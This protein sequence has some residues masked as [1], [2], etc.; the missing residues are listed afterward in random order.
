MLSDAAWCC[1]VMLHGAA[2]CCV[3]LRGAAWC[4]VVWC[5][6][7]LV[8]VGQQSVGWCI[9]YWCLYYILSIYKHTLTA[10]TTQQT[11]PQHTART[12]CLFTHDE[13]QTSYRKCP[14]PVIWSSQFLQRISLPRCCDLF[15]TNNLQQVSPYYL[16]A[17]LFAASASPPCPASLAW[18]A[19]G[20]FPTKN[21]KEQQEARPCDPHNN[22]VRVLLSVAQI[23]AYSPGEDRIYVNHKD[24]LFAIFDGHGGGI[25]I[26]RSIIIVI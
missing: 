19:G 15:N 12:R 4:C 24:N 9:Y 13:F 5:C 23:D 3:V 22:T 7:L 18:F 17:M 1:C 14:N 21:V 16:H 20:S 2:W 8:V 25:L 10:T 26:T 6:V 11:Q